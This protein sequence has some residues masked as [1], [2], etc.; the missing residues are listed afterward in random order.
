MTVATISH[1]VIDDKG[2]PRLAGRRTRVID[3]VLDQKAYGFTPAQIQEQHPH[4]SMA[5]IHAALA[6]YYDQQAELDADID[7]RDKEV[8]AMRAAAETPEFVKRL[9]RARGLE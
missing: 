8:Q 3:I 6:Y 4:L 7:R 9:R 2:V 1:V 5:Q